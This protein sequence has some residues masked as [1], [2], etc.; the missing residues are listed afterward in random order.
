MIQFSNLTLHPARLLAR[1]TSR[2]SRHECW[3]ILSVSAIT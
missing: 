3:E 2:E 1:I